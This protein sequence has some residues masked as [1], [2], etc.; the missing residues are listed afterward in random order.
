MKKNLTIAL[1]SMAIFCQPASVYAVAAPDGKTDASNTPAAQNGNWDRWVDKW[2]NIENDWTYVSL[3]PGKDETEMN[4]AWYSKIGETVSFKYGLKNDL[5]D[6]ITVNIESKEAQEGYM[7]NKVTLTN[8]KAGM[9]YYYQVTG[10]EIA[11]FTTDNDP[12]DFSFIFVGDPQIGSSNEEKAK[13]PEDIAKPTFL[14]AQSEAVRNDAFNWNDTLNKAYA[15]TNNQASFILSAGDQIQTNAKKVENYTIS[16]K[17]YTG[18]LSPDILKSLPVATSVGNHDADNPNYTYHFNQPNMSDLGSNG[19]TG[20]DYYYT[21]GDVLFIM[22]NTQDTNINEHKQFI[23]QTVKA[24]P[25]CKWRVVTLH[26]DIY[27]SAEHSNE[28][29]IT[30]LRYEL[31]AILEDNDIDVVLT[32]HDHA[33]SRSKMLKGGKKTNNYTDDE[34]D[35]QLEKDM[36]AGENPETLTVAPGNIKDNTTDPD[37]QTYLEYLKSVMDEDAIE[38]TTEGK[39][40][41]INSDGILYLTAGSSS[42]SKY[43]DLV[44]RQQTYIANRWQEDVPTYTVINV[45]ET[46][47]TINTY[48]SDTD[49]KIDSQFTIVKSVNHDDLTNLIEQAYTYNQNDYTDDSYN[50]LLQALQGAI[51]INNQADATT[52]ELANAY[53]ALNEAINSLVKKISNEGSDES[54]QPIV[55]GENDKK[56]LQSS[57]KTDDTTSLVLPLTITAISMT[58]IIVFR[59]K[60][61]NKMGA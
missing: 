58:G 27:G 28:P 55:A 54:L 17:E 45:T 39:D 7:T 13:K 41:A 4:F 51:T 10:K 59:K 49:E 50:V 15:K 23:E 21:Y 1:L 29:E 47:F 14:A 31:T 32:G 6:G 20:G 2:A 11:K 33:Y 19:I 40:V 8:L 61:G 5:S 48:R 60:K 34:F 3:A 36:D 12:N 56:N 18:Y 57:V 35:S 26:Q 24:N 9:T 46:T 16:E 53:T 43:Y 22:L 42:G 30:N 44:P 38:K 37:E 52:I 25:N